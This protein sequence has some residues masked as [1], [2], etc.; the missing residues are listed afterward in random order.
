MTN[1]KYILKKVYGNEC[2]VKICPSRD[3]QVIRHLLLKAEIVS[4]ICDVEYQV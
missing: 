1:K 3:W 4:K 2:G